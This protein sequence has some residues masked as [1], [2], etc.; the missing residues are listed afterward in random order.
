MVGEAPEPSRAAGETLVEL[1][2]AGLNPVDVAIAA[3]RFYLP[4]PDPPRV[5][6][7][8][9]VGRVLESDTHPAGAL[10]W[11][12]QYSGAF[13]ERFIIADEAAVPVPDGVDPVFA[14]GIGIAGLAG[15]MPVRDRGALKPAETVVVLGATGIA[16]RVAVQAARGAAGRIVGVGRNPEVLAQLMALGADATVALADDVDLTAALRDACPDGIDLVVDALWGA[17]LAATIPVLRHGAR[18]VQVGSAAGQ[19]SEIVA[20]TLRGR[21]IDIRGFSVFSES[22]DDVAR[23]YTAMVRELGD[24]REVMPI[25]RVP[26]DAAPAAFAA[27][28]AA[29]AA[30]KRVLIP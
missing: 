19:S 18:V 30:V 23:A 28:A 21:R 22:R 1:V 26:L 4:L 9:A 27:Q 14:A 12:L 7:A 3:G 17:P 11:T 16:G 13:A 29:G 25:E 10:V 20:G 6:G 2:A 15:W 5:A 24:G 8:E